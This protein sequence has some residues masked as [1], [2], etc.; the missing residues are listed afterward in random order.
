M[1]RAN[2]IVRVLQIDNTNEEESRWYYSIYL[3]TFKDFTSRTIYKGYGQITKIL[4]YSWY[5]IQWLW[6]HP[7]FLLLSSLEIRFNIALKRNKTVTIATNSIIF[8]I[9]SLCAWFIVEIFKKLINIQ[10]DLG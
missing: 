5:E 3:T 4:P 10:S 8:I 2:K 1:T 6:T 9:E 7:S